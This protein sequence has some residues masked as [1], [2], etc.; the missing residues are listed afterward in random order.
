MMTDD[1]TNDYEPSP[2]EATELPPGREPAL[3][4][5]DWAGRADRDREEWAAYCEAWQLDPQSTVD[6]DAAY[7]PDLETLRLI[8]AFEAECPE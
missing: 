5:D 4:Y 2:A 6:Y 1:D 7:R 8:H 3:G